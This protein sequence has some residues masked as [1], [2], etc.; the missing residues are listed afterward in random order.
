MFPALK[1]HP[2]RA[3]HPDLFSLVPLEGQKRRAMTKNKEITITEPLCLEF[4]AD[5]QTQLSMM[6]QT[7]A[8]TLPKETKY[9][10][11]AGS[12]HIANPGPS[13]LEIVLLRN[14]CAGRLFAEPEFIDIDRTVYLLDINCLDI[15]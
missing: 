1:T 6:G 10:V 7:Y 9:I 12:Y 5:Y 14:Q 15:S 11:N 4:M 2:L 8:W 3:A 13:I